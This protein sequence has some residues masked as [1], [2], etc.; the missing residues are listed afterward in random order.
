M[1]LFWGQLSSHFDGWRPSLFRIILHNALHPPIGV[2]PP[3]TQ[4]TVHGKFNI[5]PTPFG[6][7]TE[8]MIVLFIFES[9]ALVLPSVRHLREFL[10]DVAC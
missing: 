9:I 1:N 10:T 5:R 2:A 7:G 6:M 8:Q 3:L 4:S